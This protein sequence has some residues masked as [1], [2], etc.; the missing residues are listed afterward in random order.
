V[1]Y[2]QALARLRGRRDDAA[3]AL[4]RAEKISPHHL[5][6]HPGGRPSLN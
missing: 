6:H 1:N 5:Y 3:L 4:R 2:G